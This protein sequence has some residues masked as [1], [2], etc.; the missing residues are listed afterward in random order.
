VKKSKRN[1]FLHNIFLILLVLFL[2]FNGLLCPTQSDLIIFSGKIE[3]TNEPTLN[4]DF[5]E[6]IFNIKEKN[7]NKIPILSERTIEELVTI[8]FP[9]DS[10]IIPMD[11]KQNDII[12]SFGF[13]HALLRNNSFI[14][15]IIE[16][17]N[18]K[19]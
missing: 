5:K 15:R 12:K 2:F 11:D 4:I 16:P 13:V 7:E 1:N 17:P 19:I 6:G 14:Y 9:P 3:S 8:T 10:Y 18:V